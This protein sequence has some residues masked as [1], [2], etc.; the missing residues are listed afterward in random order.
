MIAPPTMEAT[1]KPDP[2]PV[3]G[4][5]PCKPRVKMLGNM[6]ELNRPI[7]RIL[8]MAKC[9]EVNMEV[10]TNRQAN[11]AQIASKLSVRIFCSKAEPTKRPIMAPPQ[12]R[13]T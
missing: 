11:D 3:S 7:A 9:P 6:I 12:Y 1:S 10:I 4:P 8:H 5:K 13:E 2:L